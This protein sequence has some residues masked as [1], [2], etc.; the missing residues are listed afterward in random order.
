MKTPAH[1]A[2]EKWISHPAGDGLPTK[3]RDLQKSVKYFPPNGHSAESTAYC[4][5]HNLYECAYINIFTDWNSLRNT[6]CGVR[7]LWHRTWL[8]CR[9][10]SRRVFFSRLE[11]D[12]YPNIG[13]WLAGCLLYIYQ[14]RF[15]SQ[16]NRVLY[17]PPPTI[18]CIYCIIVSHRFSLPFYREMADPVLFFLL[19]AV[20]A[21]AV[22]L[23]ACV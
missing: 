8:C 19:T 1:T 16:E 9:A 10:N 3:W 13:L 5:T 6:V 14:T 11:I 21:A 2:G 4:V 17:T 18:W 22:C 12:P 23:C 7:A 15:T 20:A